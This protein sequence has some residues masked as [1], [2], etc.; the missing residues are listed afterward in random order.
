LLLFFQNS[1]A[2]NSPVSHPSP[3]QIARRIKRNELNPLFAEV[4]AG[5]S[6]RSTMVMIFLT[7]APRARTA[8]V[9]DPP[10]VTSSTG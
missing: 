9:T 1:S 2:G 8:C 3:E 6:S 4:F 7:L 5:P 10:S